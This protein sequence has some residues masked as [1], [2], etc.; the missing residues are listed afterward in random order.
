MKRQ[1]NQ[2]CWETGNKPFVLLG[3]RKVLHNLFIPPGLF[4]VLPT[5]TKKDGNWWWE[6]GLLVGQDAHMGQAQTLPGLDS[7]TVLPI[8]TCYSVV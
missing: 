1:E 2:V 5:K 3:N 8:P 6:D 4:K 7:K